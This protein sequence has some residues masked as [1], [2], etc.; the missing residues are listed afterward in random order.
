MA[1][2]GKVSVDLD[3]SGA[4][5]SLAAELESM[6]RSLRGPRRCVGRPAFL[7]D[8]GEISFGLATLHVDPFPECAKRARAAMT[9][10]ETL[11]VRL[12]DNCTTGEPAKWNVTP[13][14]VRSVLNELGD[15]RA[16]LTD[17]VE[18]PAEEAGSDEVSDAPAD[19]R[20]HNMRALHEL[21]P[22]PVVST[23]LVTSLASV[24]RFTS[25][26]KEAYGSERG[27]RRVPV[28]C[29]DLSVIARV[30]GQAMARIEND[31]RC[32][33]TFIGDVDQAA[34]RF[35]RDVLRGLIEQ[36]EHRIIPSYGDTSPERVAELNDHLTRAKV[37]FK[38]LKRERL[39]GATRES[40][41][42]AS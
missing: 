39:V 27:E 26:A 10:A 20:L 24:E 4:R 13:E 1:A 32:V 41:E 9:K 36:L 19:P 28:R 16:A 29:Q 40:A 25:Y 23:D 11:I 37:A 42:V 33:E 7:N 18:V 21:T 3:F 38:E 30:A 2:V 6:A 12:Q 31:E 14:E 34:V 22:P 17:R 15:A 5:E 35:A 8:R